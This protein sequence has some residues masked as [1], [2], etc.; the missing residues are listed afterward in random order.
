M[1]NSKKPS[2]SLGKTNQADSEI[3][4]PQEETYCYY[5][6]YKYSPGAWECIEG[7]KSLCTQSGKWNHF[8]EKC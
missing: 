8:N 6:G 7:K 1:E 5:Q 4:G 3:V 2:T